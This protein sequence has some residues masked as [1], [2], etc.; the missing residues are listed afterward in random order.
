MHL[1][2]R[3]DDH[4]AQARLQRLARTLPEQTRQAARAALREEAQ[5]LTP[6]LR[7]H[8]AASL[9]VSKRSVL[10]AI[11]AKVYDA[12]TDRMPA[13]WVGSK[14]PWLGVHEH[15]ATIGG[16]MLIPING[17]IGRK[18]FKRI[19]DGLMRQGNAFF[20]RNR[21]GQVVLM[22][23]NIAESDPLLRGVKRRYRKAEGIKRLK[24]GVD[25]PIAVMVNRVTVRRRLRVEQIVMGRVPAIGARLIKTMR[26]TD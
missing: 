12:K 2:L 19:V 14:V 7:A 9:Q 17:R 6:L 10:S 18:T 11:K 26:I 3:L 22:A 4:D 15:G 25:V 1:R 23:E 21:R 16:K 8:V 13:L 20:V 24:R 5:F